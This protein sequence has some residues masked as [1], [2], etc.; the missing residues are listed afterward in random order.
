M[1]K[2]IVE[3]VLEALKA[4]I[5]YDKDTSVMFSNKDYSSVA[6]SDDKFHNISSDKVSKKVA[7]I[8]GGNLEVLK[9]PNFSLQFMRIASIIY[10]NSNIIKKQVREYYIL[11]TSFN[12]DGEIYYKG[13][14]FPFDSSSF[15]SDWKFEFNS[16]DE[17]LGRAN[18]RASISSIGG[19]VRN[20]LEIKEA[21][22]ILDDVDIV[23]R[24]GNLQATNHLEEQFFDLCLGKARADRKI[25]C[26][27]AKTSDLL[28]DAGNSVSDYLS[29]RANGLGLK[30]WY[31]YPSVEI[32]SARHRADMYYIRLHASSKYVFRLDVCNT[33]PYNIGDLLSMLRSYSTDPVFLGYPYGLIKVD[34]LARVS[35]KEAEFIKMKIVSKLGKGFKELEGALNSL[36]SH[37]ILDNIG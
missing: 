14:V 17:D 27:V 29:N 28:T 30:E 12:Q 25:V 26:G 21:E 18:F 6:F 11:I 19:I 1:D 20:L 35:I 16:A 37:S 23:V 13:E 15:A 36:N 34:S 24:D 8:D 2:K 4:R 7:F 31:Y 3:G 10:E 5:N 33:V 9:A 22:L 32:N